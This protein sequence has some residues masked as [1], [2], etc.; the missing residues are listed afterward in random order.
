MSEQDHRDV[1]A[2]LRTLLPSLEARSDPL[3]KRIESAPLR[4]LRGFYL[5]AVSG[6]AIAQEETDP[7]RFIERR[8]LSLLSAAHRA[9][10]T[11]LTA[12]V[13][14]SA[15]V[16]FYVG[17][18][19][20]G[21]TTADPTV[22]ERLLR[23][24]LPGLEV[25]FVE[26]A[27]VESFLKDKKYGGLVA[28]VP[29][30]T[31]DDERQHCNLPSV[32][33]SMHG[34]DFA[35]V[36]VSQ[37]VPYDEL[38]QQLRAL[39]DI[40]DRCHELGRTT[41]IETKGTTESEQVGQTK[42]KTRG[43]GVSLFVSYQ[44][45][46]SEG[47]TKTTGTGRHWSEGLSQE[48]QNT[49]ALELERLA[50]HHAN[51]LWKATNVGGWETA[52]TFATRTPAGRDILAGS[53][54]GELAKP[55]TDVFPPQVYYDDLSPDRPLLLPS[56][57]RMSPI[58]P[59][60]LASYLTSEELAALAAPPAEQLPGYEIRRTPT[61]SLAD[62][63]SASSGAACILGS[64]C[65]HG[66]ALPEI[67][68]TISADDLA[69]HLFVC[70]L[71][72]TGKTTTVKKILTGVR[73][74]FL[75]IESAKRDYRRLL[76]TKELGDR[77]RVYTVGDPSI[78]PLC[79]NPFFVMPGVSPLVHIDFLKAIF[80]A[81][82]SLYGPMPYILEQCLHNIYVKRGWNLTDGSHPYLW[83]KD[84]LAE[85]RYRAA[86]AVHWFPTLADLTEEVEQYVQTRL[87]YR[88]E[89]SDNIRTAIVTR[90]KSLSV[91]AK[92][93]LF[94]TSQP[95]DIAELLRHP[96][97]LELEA[98]SD[99]DDKA[100]FVGL[101]LTFISEYRQCHNPELNPYVERAGGLQHLLVIEEAHRLLK[102]I[103][104]ERYT[105]QLGN[106]RGKAVEFFANV[107]A[108]M[109]GMGQGVIVVEQIPTKILP[110]VI[111]NTGTK[112]VHRLVARDDQMLLAAS[113][114]LGEDE[115]LYL[116]SLATGH[117][118]YLKEGMPRA[119]EVAVIPNVPSIR[120][121]H[122]RVQKVMQ[123]F[124]PP[125][126]R[127]AS[128]A[129]EIRNV[130]DKDGD[131]I[132]VR[133]LCSLATSEEAEGARCIQGALAALQSALLVRDR[134][135]APSVL[136]RYLGDRLVGLLCCGV[137][138]L[139]GDTVYGL[140]G[141]VTALLDGQSGAL[142]KFHTRLAKG[143]GAGDV[144]EGCLQRIQE[145]V[146]ERALRAGL[147][148]ASQGDLD[149]IASTYFLTDD[150]LVR[151]EIVARVVARLGGR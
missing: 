40:K 51:R 46:T 17:F 33:R 101:M 139:D 30:L 62:A 29:A 136:K 104:Q 148:R 89:L 98:L 14:S 99:D 70:G 6:L 125:S 121:S 96:T 65:D 41:R 42:T 135:F 143:W 122:E 95:L 73:V 147:S 4:Q 15:G 12:V 64:V 146:L 80:N 67:H 54:V 32:L 110:D 18:R 114:G 119:T 138:R 16:E 120:I 137:F 61:L 28:G 130:L 11:V 118:L 37:P 132:A 134:S 10:W 27:T 23:G 106:P 72:G 131:A 149:R 126:A 36:I 113:L 60:S 100:F 50:E 47:E 24:L 79:M 90:L 94:G 7:A 87:Q 21:S 93:L 66:R 105:E 20:A 109:R 97:V 9:G 13:G 52:I 69:K 19:A 45:P 74:P 115:S 116:T 58:F 142:G 112:I 26:R 31:V 34:E 127:E 85:D 84:G 22:F 59:R 25:R 57:D 68:V 3:E 1:Q 103:V 35:L 43:W 44:R 8:F 86:E 129:E 76:G 123:T 111:K 48:E 128:R 81:S 71:T 92:G 145:L 83:G 88:G 133:T 141:V 63:R 107:I 2:A 55:S 78:A 53:L 102:N 38:G 77:L 117:A 124:L 49:V 82:F 150:P 91:G 56:R 39:W 140:T 151:Q 144:R 5:F 75:V 108:E